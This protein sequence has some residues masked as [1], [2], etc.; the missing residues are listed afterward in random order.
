MKGITVQKGLKH[1]ILRLQLEN[2]S[3]V[4]VVKE[5]K[6]YSVTL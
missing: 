2:V 3:T 5:K 4:H 6:L 1:Q